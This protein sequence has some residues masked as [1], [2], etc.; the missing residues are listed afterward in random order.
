MNVWCAIDK[1]VHSETEWDNMSASIPEDQ[2]IVITVAMGFPADDFPAND[3][4]FGWNGQRKGKVMDSG[5]YVFYAEV[6]LSNGE[7]NRTIARIS[8][9]ITSKQ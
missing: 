7:L 5:V 1:W 4:S 6:E 3:V 8:M 9:R 2:L